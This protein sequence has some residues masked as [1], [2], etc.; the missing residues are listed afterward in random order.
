M[1]IRL[2]TP[3]L[4]LAS[5]A[6]GTLLLGA[7]AST[8]GVHAYGPDA[9]T[10]TVDNGSF[11]K[12]RMRALQHATRFCARQ[13]RVLAPI[14]EK[15]E[16]VGPN[17]GYGAMT[18]NFKCVEKTGAAAAPTGGASLPPPPGTPAPRKME[19]PST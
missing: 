11:G 3:R 18:L 13:D 9:Y 4:A 5:L 10:I 16:K 14:D 6:I 17:D 1:T 8:T 19:E 12:V 7:C 2:T 15:Y